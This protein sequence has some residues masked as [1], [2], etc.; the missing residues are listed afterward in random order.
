MDAVVRVV[1]AGQRLVLARL[2]LVR[3]DVNDLARRSAR[4]GVLVAAGGF[5]LAAA[6]CAL[7]AA[8]AAWLR[9][10]LPLPVS[11]VVVAVVTA[12]IGVAAILVGVSSARPDRAPPPLDERR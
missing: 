11:L 1:D 10:Y 4:S 2:D 5:L 7:M 8:A 12:A 6:W 9:A 3:A